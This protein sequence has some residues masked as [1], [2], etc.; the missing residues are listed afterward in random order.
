MNFEQHS[1]SDSDAKKHHRTGIVIFLTI[2]TFLVLSG[3]FSIVRIAIAA[4]N[5]LQHL[6]NPT[7]IVLVFG[8]KLMTDE[9][10]RTNVLL[11]GG[12]GL[13][14]DEGSDLT[15]TLMVGSLDHNTGQIYIISVPRDLFIQIPNLGYY[16]VNTLWPIGKANSEE[17]EE[18]DLAKQAFRSILGLDIHYFA[19]I[20]FDGFERVIDALG[21]IDVIVDRSFTDYEYPDENYGYM[22]VSFEAGPQHMDGST[23]L[24]YAR[25]RHGNNN[26]SGDFA[27]ATRQ[28]KVI[29]ALK[30]KAMDL[31]LFGAPEQLQVVI[32]TINNHY[33]TDVT[34]AEMLTFMK[35]AK[36]LNDNGIHNLVIQE[37]PGELLYVP[38]EEI[39]N[40]YY[41]GAYV[42]L[43][44]GDDFELIHKK[45][46][47]FLVEPELI[48]SG[49][50]IEVL[51]GTKTPNLAHYVATELMR[52]GV[53]IYPDYGIR[54]AYY[55]TGYDQTI[56]YDH[57]R[58]GNIEL[59]KKIQSVI[60]GEIAAENPEPD[61]YPVDI[62]VIIGYD[63][64]V[65]DDMN[66][67]L[68]TDVNI[69]IEDY[70][71]FNETP[72]D[73]EDNL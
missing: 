34:F 3:M 56:I 67:T 27:R 39:R 71:G 6:D 28:Q 30:D 64:D 73:S 37:G 68:G 54:N 26:E 13:A 69:E 24:Q 42:L 48:T 33:V 66:S 15:D 12:G 65:P 31:G 1:I 10:N 61:M 45:V 5:I 47:E 50:T 20:D 57:S 40:Q 72:G 25:S 4:S 43:P 41:G 51:N 11:L 59:A 32:D 58:G 62:T 46:Q 8:T 29:R 18:A 55:K 16:R 35:F 49:P 44:D 63:F 9:N 2:I 38:T 36:D 7:E 70:D 22:T 52:N 19:K 21:G 23:A 53:R 60:G 14:H 17:G